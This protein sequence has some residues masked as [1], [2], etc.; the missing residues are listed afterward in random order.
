M[1]THAWR[2]NYTK[3]KIIVE[4]APQLYIDLDVESDG[5][6]G[7][8]SLLSIGAVTPGG[9]TFY[10]ELCPTSDVWIAGNREF[11]ETH[12]LERN[13]LLREGVMPHDAVKELDMWVRGM[14]REYGKRTAVLVAFNASY[15]FPLIDLEFKRAN[16][17]T[18]FGI[19]G[20]CVKSLAA[21]VA[22]GYDWSFTAKHNLPSDVLP[23]DDFTHNALEDAIYQQKLHFALIGRG[24]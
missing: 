22:P 20:Y 8:G 17:P 9:D 16:I 11:C 18:P 14:S 1:A 4:Q 24:H 2:Q 21:A 15:D 10:K 3:G 19:A 13:R 12:N 7:H 23:D 6:A 5:I